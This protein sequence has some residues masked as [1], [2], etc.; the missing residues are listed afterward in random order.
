MAN[1][2][3]SSK[4]LRKL[5]VIEIITSKSIDAVDLTDMLRRDGVLTDKNVAEIAISRNKAEDL[6]ILLENAKKSNI[7]DLL[8][9]EWQM[10]PNERVVLTIVTPSG[11]REFRHEEQ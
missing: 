4:K 8:D 6:F 2:L 7:L 10:L 9:Y 11:I 1:D 5:K 3:P